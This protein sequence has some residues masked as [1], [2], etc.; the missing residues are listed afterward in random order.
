MLQN[1]HLTN[2]TSS[3]TSNE[4]QRV[5]ISSSTSSSPLSIIASPSAAQGNIQLYSAENAAINSVAF[6]SPKQTITTSSPADNY[7]HNS[8]ASSQSYPSPSSSLLMP[9]NLMT[10]SL[11]GSPGSRQ[12][13]QLASSSGRPLTPSAEML[14]NQYGL[15]RSL[16]A[17]SSYNDSSMLDLNATMQQA[18]DERQLTHDHFNNNNSS[19]INGN[20]AVSS[21]NAQLVA[22]DSKIEQAMDLVKTHLIFAVREEVELLRSKILELETTV[23]QLEA[24]NSILREHVPAEILQNLTLQP[25]AN[26]VS[27][28]T[29][30]AAQ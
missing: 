14:L 28:S 15:E 7:G 11:L 21:Q 26:T 1:K 10:Q 25:G 30:M 22:I 3:R 24:E 6:S 19:S 23:I 29:M 5:P 12:Q 8:A 9:A 4:D 13:Q 17:T 18:V 20:N 27:S 2:G 16:S